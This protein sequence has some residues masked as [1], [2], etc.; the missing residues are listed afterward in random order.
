MCNCQTLF[1][2]EKTITASTEYAKLI[3]HRLIDVGMTQVQLIDEVK[4]RTG[5]Y[6]DRSYMK[7]IY[8]GKCRPEK[9]VTAINEI[10]SIEG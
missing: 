7:K 4:E 2:K 1:R 3:K 6:L 5:L 9:I 10:L 8:D